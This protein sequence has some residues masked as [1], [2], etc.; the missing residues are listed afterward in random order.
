MGKKKLTGKQERFVQEYLIDLNATQ[1]AIRA[2][3]S[4]KSAMQIGEQNLRK[5]EIAERIK[6]A[7]AA[8]SQ[9][10][11]ITRER[12]LEE[13]ARIA[14]HKPGDFLETRESEDGHKYHSIKDDFLD[15]ENI[16]AVQTIEP[17]RFGF[18]LKMNDK[19]AALDKLSRHLGLFN[20]D[21]SQ[22][23]ETNNFD[24]TNISSEKLR[25]IQEILKDES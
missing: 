4:P 24:F 3:Y 13:L 21:T 14:F 6:E 8:T 25:K 23:P 12:V 2:G 15:H 16:A 11:E 7:R 5:H 19:V 10:L 20:A 18:K 1:A 9:K 22:K 17:T